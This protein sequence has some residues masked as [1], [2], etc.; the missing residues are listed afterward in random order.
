MEMPERRGPAAFGT[1]AVMNHRRLVERPGHPY[2]TGLGA[3]TRKEVILC[4]TIYRGF[5]LL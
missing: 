3:T 1:I 2:I 5:P 4:L